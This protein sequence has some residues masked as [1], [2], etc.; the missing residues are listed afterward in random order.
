M[1]NWIK[2]SDR[3]P[4]EGGLYWVIDTG[5]KEDTPSVE[6]ATLYINKAVIKDVSGQFVSY[7]DDLS[8]AFYCYSD[9][10]GGEDPDSYNHVTHWAEFEW[11]DPPEKE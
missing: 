4:T 8:K 2:I 1:V 7:D 5:W 10:M 9:A 3:K 11:P 6:L